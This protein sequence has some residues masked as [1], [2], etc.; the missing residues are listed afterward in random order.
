VPTRLDGVLVISLRICAEL[1]LPLLL[2]LIGGAP[3]GNTA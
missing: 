3:A 1:S 2:A